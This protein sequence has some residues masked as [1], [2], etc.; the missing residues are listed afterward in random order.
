MDYVFSHSCRNPDHLTEIAH[1][2]EHSFSSPWSRE[3]LEAEFRNP[4]NLVTIIRLS[5][6]TAITGYSLTRLLPPEAELLRIAI[7]PEARGAGAGSALLKALLQHLA[8]LKMTK[9]YLE[10]SAK[11]RSAL[12][13][14]RK[15]GF[16]LTGQRSGYYDNG[17]SDAL[18]FTF[19]VD[20][21]Q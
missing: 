6:A 1:L 14:Y 11:N 21:L 10:V 4:L 20:S 3:S 8:T 7:Q 16:V 19:T 2:E 9:V 12:S 5:S 13:L 18:T 15:A 17:S